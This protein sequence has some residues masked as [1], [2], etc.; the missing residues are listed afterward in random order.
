[1]AKIVG[2]VRAALAVMLGTLLVAAGASTAE[3][4]TDSGFLSEL[5]LG[6][7]DQSIDGAVSETGVSVSAEALFHPLPWSSGFPALDRVIQPRPHLGATINTG[8]DTSLA[9]AG[10]SWTIPLY[11][12]RL[13]AEASLGAAVHN[14]PRDAPGI[15]SYGCSWGFRET[16]S[17][18]WSINETWRLLGTFEHMSNADYCAR[19]RGLTNAGVRLGYSLD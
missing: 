5:R 19:N 9:Y 18:G 1:M 6:I 13:F 17:L 10:L 2:R 11:G 7:F 16:L 12:N 15:A 4:Q 8:G 3:A 14:G